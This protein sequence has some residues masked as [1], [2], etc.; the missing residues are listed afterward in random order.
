MNNELKL[1]LDVRLKLFLYFKIDYDNSEREQHVQVPN[2]ALASYL[3]RTNNDYEDF[4]PNDYRK[5]SMAR[6]RGKF[7]A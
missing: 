4:Y 7:F 1:P 2:K 5:R 3:A 6:K